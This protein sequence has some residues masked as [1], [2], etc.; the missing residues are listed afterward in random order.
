LKKAI[1]D[2][3][4]EFSKKVNL[5]AMEIKINQFL[6]YLEHIDE[7]QMVVPGLRSPRKLERGD[8]RKESFALPSMMLQILAPKSIQNSSAAS[9]NLLKQILKVKLLLLWW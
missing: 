3:R 1:E 5:E 6:Y 2:G 7:L 4:T 8:L 9:L